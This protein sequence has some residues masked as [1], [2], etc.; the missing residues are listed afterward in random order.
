MIA[1]LIAFAW[2][3]LL[4]MGCATFDYAWVKTRPA[5]EKP[6]QYVKADNTDATCRKMGA[7]AAGKIGYITACA[8][9]YPRGCTIILPHGD[10][11][12]LREHEERH[13][14]GWTH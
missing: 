11:P 6:W 4:T 10:H 12:D 5:S 7:D 13:C 3:L 1:T 14:A 9:W 2:A 8:Q